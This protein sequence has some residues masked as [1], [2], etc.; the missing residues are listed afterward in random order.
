M[1]ITAAAELSPPGT[2]AYKWYIS[3]NIYQINLKY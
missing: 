3:S 2:Q 1:N